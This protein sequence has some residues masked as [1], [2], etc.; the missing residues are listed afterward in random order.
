MLMEVRPS[1]WKFGWHLAFCWLLV[2]W[3]IALYRRSA[4]LMRIYPD[5]VAIEEG[6]WSRQSTEFF[7]KDIRSVDVRQ[8]FWGR[9][10]DIGDVTVATAAAVDGAEEAR[11]VAH[12]HRIKE[13]LIA[14]RQQ[15]GS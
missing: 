7:I 3:F 15:S 1:W 8:G 11:G 12:P 9:L 5:R 10:V 2:P 14:R 4:F 6:V 13:L